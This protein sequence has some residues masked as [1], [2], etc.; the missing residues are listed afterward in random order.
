M[1]ALRP[2]QRASQP[3]LSLG[4][5]HEVR[6]RVWRDSCTRERPTAGGKWP[7]WTRT[8]SVCTSGGRART[9]EEGYGWP[10]CGGRARPWIAQ[11][12]GN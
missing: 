10:L 6:G 8:Q 3:F 11:D 12:G 5:F 1:R 4:L 7:R 2:R 9:V